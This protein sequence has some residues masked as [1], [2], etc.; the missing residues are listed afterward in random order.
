MAK[1]QTDKCRMLQADNSG[2][3]SQDHESTVCVIII[4]CCQ[5][6]GVKK[7]WSASHLYGGGSKNLPD[8]ELIHLEMPS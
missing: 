3:D 7:G 8:N 2:T 1:L 4:T 5:L 6:T